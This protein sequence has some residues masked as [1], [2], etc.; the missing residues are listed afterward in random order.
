TRAVDAR[1]DA[2]GEG[3]AHGRK[4]DRDRP[5]G[6]LEGC[7]RRGRVCHDDVGLQTDQLLR[8]LSYPIE[9]TAGPMN[10]QAHVAGLSPTQARNG[11]RERRNVSLRH[12]IVFVVRHEHADAPHP[13]ALLRAR[14]DWPRRS[15]AEERDELAPPN[16]SITSS[17]RSMI[18]GGTA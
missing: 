9:V 8:D 3:V 16:H 13:P 5:R 2:A 11:L 4:D 15:A 12:E 18:D 1:D 6:P 17:A 7:G 14:R 10:V